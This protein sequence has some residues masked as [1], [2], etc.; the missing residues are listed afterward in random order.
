MLR[1][2]KIH[3]PSATA[4]SEGIYGRARNLMI[5]DYPEKW[6]MQTK[7]SLDFLPQ[8]IEIDTFNSHSHTL[9]YQENSITHAPDTWFSERGG[10]VVAPDTEWQPLN[11]PCVRLG[12]WTTTGT[13]ANDVKLVPHDGAEPTY[14]EDLAYSYIQGMPYIQDSDWIWH[15]KNQL[16]AGSYDPQTQDLHSAGFKKSALP[17]DSEQKLVPPYKKFWV[18]SVDVDVTYTIA[19]TGTIPQMDGASWTYS[20]LGPEPNAYSENTISPYRGTI[21]QQTTAP[22]GHDMSLV[23]RVPI[24]PMNVVRVGAQVIQSNSRGSGASTV[25]ILN[26]DIYLSDE[27]LPY[28]LTGEEGKISEENEWNPAIADYDDFWGSAGQKTEENAEMVRSKLTCFKDHRI[29]FDG[30]PIQGNLKFTV[31][32]TK[33]LGMTPRNSDALRYKELAMSAM[34]DLQYLSMMGGH[35]DRPPL[36]CPYPLQY[37]IVKSGISPSWY[38][39]MYE[40]VLA[41]SNALL[42][43]GMS[44]GWLHELPYGSQISMQYT[45]KLKRH[46]HLY[47]DRRP[48]QRIAPTISASGGYTYGY[49]RQTADMMPFD[50][51]VAINP[52][53]GDVDI[54]DFAP[55]AKRRRI[56]DNT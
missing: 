55:G 18:S 23:T 49:H 31:V 27:N 51:S 9:E 29:C 1:N 5:T 6:K 52:K 32:P 33:F 13:D 24:P 16:A 56:G 37:Y 20:G 26:R 21:W 3:H 15:G 35:N 30:K 19:I 44:F 53:T 12:N 38:N 11:I 14:R 10:F 36:A 46:M 34:S 43:C 8:E 45:M 7:A 25:S 48:I 54:D 2:V 39:D 47:S 4:Q 41:K 22:F 50:K 40:V 28:D 42:E 17:A